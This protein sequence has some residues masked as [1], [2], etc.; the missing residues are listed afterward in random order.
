MTSYPFDRVGVAI[1][2]GINLSKDLG[3]L[4]PNICNPSYL[5]KT[6]QTIGKEHNLKVQVLERK[7]IEQLG[8]GA[9]LSVT[10]G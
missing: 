9:F 1:A 5:A 2:Q 8:M 4:P 7:E 3:N 6:A 10:Q